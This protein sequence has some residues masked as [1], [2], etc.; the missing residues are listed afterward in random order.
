MNDELE[1]RTDALRRSY[2]QM[3]SFCYSI[4]HDLRAPLR[5][6]SGFS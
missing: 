4:A 3:E 6:I 1:Q 5:S 2:E